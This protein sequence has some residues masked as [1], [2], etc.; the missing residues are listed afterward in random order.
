MGLN[1]PLSFRPKPPRGCLLALRAKPR[2][3]S[4][5]P[6][7]LP[8]AAGWHPGLRDGLAGRRPRSW[9]R[10]GTSRAPEK[11]PLGVQTAP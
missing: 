3:S 5:R 11:G 2:Q 6:E 7:Q 4:H 9:P 8:A 10:P 1:P